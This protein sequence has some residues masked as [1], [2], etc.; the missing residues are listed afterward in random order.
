MPSGHTEASEKADPS[1]LKQKSKPV[2]FP[3]FGNF[4]FFYVI[5][6]IAATTIIL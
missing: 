1:S 4:S 6:I 2:S 5:I 3:K